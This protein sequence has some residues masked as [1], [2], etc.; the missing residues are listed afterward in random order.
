MNQWLI[1]GF[2]CLMYVALAHRVIPEREAASALGHDILTNNLA[3]DPA[4]SQ[5]TRSVSDSDAGRWALKAAIDEAVPAPVLF[6]AL[7]QRCTSRV[8]AAFQDKV[9][10]AMRDGFGAHL[11]QAAS[12]SLRGRTR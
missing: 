5:F 9:L 1:K 2:K 12:T 7:Y 10:S 11:E 6:A 4:L 8:E 3:K